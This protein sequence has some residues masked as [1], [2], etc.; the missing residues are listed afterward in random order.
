MAGLTAL[1]GEALAWIE[2]AGLQRWRRKAM[3]RAAEAA[4]AEPFAVNRSL[5][6]RHRGERCFILCCGP[7][8]KQQDLRQLAGELV[9]SVSSAYMHPEFN[10]IAPRYHCVPQITAGSLTEAETVDWFRDMN[11]HLG[12]AEVVLSHYQRS[13]VER[14]GVFSGRTATFLLMEGDRYDDCDCDLTDRIP[15]PQS[16]SIMAVSLAIYLGCREIYLIGTDHDQ[17]L[18][19]TYTY[20]FDRNPIAGKDT[21]VDA[22]GR[23]RST[24]HEEFQALERLW[25]QYRWLKGVAA[26]RG[27]RIVN[28]TAGG[29]LDEFE[30][31]ELANLFER[32]APVLAAATGQ[33]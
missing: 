20:F 26:A 1:V 30:R 25:R 31:V 4:A 10:R 16:V 3:R 8:V 22:N 17:F 32:P 28:A 14:S 13:T 29:A 33:G 23:V 15:G 18:T 27:V 5:R 6:D 9:I 2:P 19:G 24:R 11:A 12:A 21:T 7:S